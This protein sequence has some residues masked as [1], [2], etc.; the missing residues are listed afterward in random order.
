MRIDG[1]NLWGRSIE[2]QRSDL[3]KVDFVHVV[4]GLK[5]QGVQDL[6]FLPTDNLSTCVSNVSLPNMAVKPEQT[7]ADSRPYMFPGWDDALGPTK[8]TFLHDINDVKLE[9]DVHRSVIYTILS[10]WRAVIRSG[11]GAMSKEHSLDLPL[12]YKVKYGFDLP[13]YLIKGAGKT[14][15]S[16]SSELD[17]DLESSAIYVLKNAWLQDM[18]ISELSY[19]Q[20]GI[21]RINA[22]FQADDFLQL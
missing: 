9:G 19:Q 21:L 14:F 8:M 7:R 16:A 20:S 4:N 6:F 11:R 22:T 17:T 15:E 13:I 12:N 2:P 18:Q 10:A 1:N 3:W 5:K